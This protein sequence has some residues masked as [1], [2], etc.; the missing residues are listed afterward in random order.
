MS[1]V[2][3]TVAALAAMREADLAEVMSMQDESVCQKPTF[4][5][6]EFACVHNIVVST[7]QQRGDFGLQSHDARVCLGIIRI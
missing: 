2:L 7:W 1:A 6:L 5:F 3:K 4:H